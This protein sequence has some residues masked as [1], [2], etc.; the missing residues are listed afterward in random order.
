MNELRGNE[1]RGYKVQTTIPCCANC[2]FGGYLGDQDEPCRLCICEIQGEP[3]D[4][5][6]C[7]VAVEPLAICDAW[8]P[9]FKVREKIDE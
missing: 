7:R 1:P 8:K 3:S 5:D 2:T 6:Y 9:G 4:S